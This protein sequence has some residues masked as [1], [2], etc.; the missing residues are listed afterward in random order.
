MSKVIPELIDTLNLNEVPSLN[1]SSYFARVSTVN[2]V[3]TIATPKASIVNSLTTIPIIVTDTIDSEVIHTPTSTV[4]FNS[5]V[6]A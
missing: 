6:S 4:I 1:H 3:I 2:N 5:Y